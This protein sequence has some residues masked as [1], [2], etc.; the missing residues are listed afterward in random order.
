MKVTR[1]QLRRLIREEYQHLLSEV[2]FHDSADEDRPGK[3]QTIVFDEEESYE[4]AG[5][6]HG[7][8]SHAIKHY[9]EFEPDKVQAAVEKEI[10]IAQESDSVHIIDKGGNVVLSDDD[11]KKQ[12]NVN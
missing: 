2:P 6:T 4:V 12:M 5:E 9:A 10:S 8:E 3:K 7:E 1:H 11:A